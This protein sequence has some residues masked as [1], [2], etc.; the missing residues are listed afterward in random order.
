MSSIVAQK[1]KQA[2]G[3][4]DELGVDAWL[5]FVRETTESGD[6]VLPLILGQNLTWQS[7]LIVTRSGDR[8]AIVGNFDA[9]AVKA[10]GIWDPV[11]PYVQDIKAPLLETL[12]RIDPQQLAVNYS[13]DDVKAD[14]FSHGMFLLLSDYLAGT[15]YADRLISADGVINALRGRKAPGEVE[16]IRRAIVETDTIFKEVADFARI[17]ATEIQ[18]AEYM[19]QRAAGRGLGLAWDPQQCPIVN[20]GPDSMIGHGIP[21]EL[22]IA[23]GHLFHIDFGIICDDYCSDLQ[24]MWYV[25]EPG[26]TAVPDALQRAFDTV[27][28]AIQAAAAAL[29]LGVECWQVDAA[30]RQ[31]VV[32]AGY[33]EYQH[34]T[35]HGVGRSAH[36]G[37]EVIG[38]RWERYGRT[39]YRKVEPGNVFT[40]ELGIENV[41]G[42]GYIGLEEM[43][44]VTETGCTYL[45]EPQT[46][47]PLL[48]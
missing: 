10:T 45:S 21:S 20:T 6:P 2:V 41:E 7:A 1:V 19:K 16:R 4:L 37:G 32:E 46:T 11:V 35:G 13:P 34:A 27:V 39:P 25:P 24:R 26:E 42:R 5:T 12:D 22:E 43:L 8:V 15:P 17:G 29:K 40:L 33:P 31:T 9:D 18:V 30:A 14:G 23:P 36:D 47:L 44:L 48:G 28:A 38:P 3:I